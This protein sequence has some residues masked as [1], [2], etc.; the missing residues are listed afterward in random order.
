MNNHTNSKFM[1]CPRFVTQRWPM[2]FGWIFLI[3]GGLLLALMIWSIPG[4]TD[5]IMLAVTCLVAV[6]CAA[7]TLAGLRMLLMPLDRVRLSGKDLRLTLFGI[8]LKRIPADD[9]HSVV[10]MIRDVRLGMKDR[11]IY[12]LHVNYKNK[13][14]RERTFLMERS[15]ASD[16]AFETY[17]SH[18]NLLL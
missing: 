10:G 2:G 8:T 16:Q 3:V 14:G 1:V 6:L 17:L 12:T 7:G 4:E 18:A 9:I 5:M 13:K 15:D 11:R